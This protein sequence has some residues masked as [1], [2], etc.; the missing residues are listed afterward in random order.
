MKLQRILTLKLSGPD[1]IYLQT[2]LKEH[3]F[4]NER[5][6]GYF[7]QNTLVA[8]TNFQRAVSV[9]ADGVVGSLTWNKLNFYGIEP[10]FNNGINH[11]ISYSNT[12][13]LIIYDHLL[14][15]DE[16][17]KEEVNK[18]TIWLHH[19]AGGSRPDWSIN[20]WEKDFKK[21]KMGR[22]VLD[23]SGNTTP[24]RVGTSY[25]IGRRSSTSD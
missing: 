12:E 7:G 9:K 6:D 3:G 1:V 13:G 8:V 16:Y 15:D 18:N 20:G 24:L 11:K 22:P 19:T 14:S 25:V 4:F 21:D 17:Y 5:I 23:P 2:K 10:E